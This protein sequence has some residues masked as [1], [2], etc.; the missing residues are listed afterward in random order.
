MSERRIILHL[1][2]DSFY[3]SIEVLERPDLARMPV[4]IGADPKGGT[5]RGVVMTASYEARAFGVRSAMPISRAWRLCP[6]GVYL[7]PRF[8]LYVEVSREIMEILSGYTDM[9]EP[10]SIDEAYLDITV[11]GS[12]PAAEDLARQIKEEIREKEQLSCSIGIGPGKIVA[13]IA[14]GHAKPDGLT[15]V[16]P[17][18]LHAFLSPLPV[19]Q[20]PGIGR[21][22]AAVLNEMGVLTIGHLAEY[23]IQA[24][25]SRFGK[26]GIALRMLARGEDDREVQVRGC[27]RSISRE[28]TFSED[29]RDPLVLTHTIERMADVLHSALCEEG[30]R[31]RTV[32]VKVRYEGFITRTKSRSLAHHSTDLAR[33]KTLARSLLAEFSLEN[34]IRLIG[35]RLSGFD[36]KKAGQRTI[37]DFY[38]TEEN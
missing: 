9:F 6:Q 19:G 26:G 7:P 22:T 18:H 11:T 29:T 12:Y 32:T 23:D 20:I 28:H 33:I 31:F 1:D 3:A 13:K 5:G 34:R 10:V 15:V 30:L 4:I 35:L 14:S 8:P 17:D 37:G 38:G 36:Q 2:M 21:K 16:D 27:S 25:V 24:L